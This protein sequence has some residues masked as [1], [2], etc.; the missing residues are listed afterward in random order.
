M[1]EHKAAIRAAERERPA[2]V[3]AAADGQLW[4][5]HE[6]RG[7]H[8]LRGQ[9]IPDDAGSQVLEAWAGTSTRSATHAHNYLFSQMGFDDWGFSRIDI[10]D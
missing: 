6:R 2:A 5:G 9:I 3:Q 8:L 1:V 7:L 10:E 4:V